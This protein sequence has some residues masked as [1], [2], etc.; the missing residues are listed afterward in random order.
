MG[1]AGDIAMQRI[2]TSHMSPVEQNRKA[3]ER[4]CREVL[5]HGNL[6][7]IDDL[8]DASVVSHTPFPG[9]TPGREGFKEAFA[10]FRAAFPNLQIFIRD[11]VAGG[12][13]VVGYFTVTGVHSGEFMGI[14]ATGKLV[15]YDEIV[16][17]RFARGKIAEHWS[18][19]DTL[20]MMLALGAVLYKSR[21][22]E[23]SAA[24][25]ER[26]TGDEEPLLLGHGLS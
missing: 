23:L 26:S 7:A 5:V 18:V 8:V 14:A 20:A 16:I 10:Q 25:A 11:I 24:H 9:Q 3:Y 17:V 1:D 6:E 15:T 21:D 12:D 4:F 2:G 13:K 19:A 22:P